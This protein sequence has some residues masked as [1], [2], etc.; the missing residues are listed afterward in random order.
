MRSR[1]PLSGLC[2]PDVDG[3][4][5]VE[6]RPKTSRIHHH[7]ERHMVAARQ[8]DGRADIALTDEVLLPVLSAEE[9]EAVFDPSI[10]FDDDA[11]HA[12]RLA[13]S[14]ERGASGREVILLTSWESCAPGA[15]FITPPGRG[16][17]RRPAGPSALP[18]P[19]SSRF[20]PWRLSPARRRRD[21]SRS[22]RRAGSGLHPG[23]TTG[24]RRDRKSTRLNSS[25]GYIS[26]AVFCL[27]TK[28]SRQITTSTTS[29]VI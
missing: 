28:N 29:I 15:T 9:A 16:C 12:R 25:H 14:P 27:K 20:M 21:P 10:Q 2:A 4:R 18:G 23:R 26:Y 1:A 3:L 19:A 5:P 24:P 13:D 8:L 7:V 17:A 22:P 11:G 6:G